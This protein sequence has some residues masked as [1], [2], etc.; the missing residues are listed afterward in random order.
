MRALLVTCDYLVLASLYCNSVGMYSRGSPDTGVCACLANPCAIF[1]VATDALLA[2]IYVVVSCGFIGLLN[3]LI[4]RLMN[5]T[6]MSKAARRRQTGEI[7]KVSPPTFRR[8]LSSRSPA[9]AVPPAPQL[10]AV[11]VAN[12]LCQLARLA[13]LAVGPVHSVVHSTSDV[14]TVSSALVPV[15]YGG[16]EVRLRAAIP[17]PGC[18]LRLCLRLRRHGSALFPNHP[19]HTHTPPPPLPGLPFLPLPPHLHRRRQRPQLCPLR[20]GAHPR[21][22]RLQRRRDHGAGGGTAGRAIRGGAT[23]PRLARARRVLHRAHPRGPAAGH[24]PA[25]TLPRK[26]IFSLP[27]SGPAAC[28]QQRWRW[29][30]RRS[31]QARG[32]RGRRRAERRCAE[33]AAVD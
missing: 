18:R 22:P 15:V 28:R 14:P 8:A 17:A 10:L 16:L 12:I 9:H 20:R 11:S 23:P 27:P 21:A 31:G 1:T 4:R 25:L 33:C 30:G 13:L 32:R 6:T 24:R 7:A 5:T 3:K 2:V 29:W 26:D 19:T